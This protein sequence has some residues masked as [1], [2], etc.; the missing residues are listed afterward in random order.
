MENHSFDSLSV[1]S[2]RTK[3]RGKYT[4]GRS[5]SRVRSKSLGDSLKELCWIFDKPGNFKKN[6]KSKSVEK[7]KG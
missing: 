5:K 6:C 3:E 2:S 7:G 4:R 1:I